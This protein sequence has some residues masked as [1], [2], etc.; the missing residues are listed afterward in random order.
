MARRKTTAAILATVSV[1]SENGL[2]TQADRPTRQA[3]WPGEDEYPAPVETTIANRD[4]DFTQF[5][6][7]DVARRQAIEDEFY[8]HLAAEQ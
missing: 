7:D 3:V 2:A 6:R 5:V 4:A 1:P 8:A